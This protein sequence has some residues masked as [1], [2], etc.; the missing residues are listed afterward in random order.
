MNIDNNYLGINSAMDSNSI[1]SNGSSSSSINMNIDSS[2]M[3]VNAGGLP[4]R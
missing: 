1:N 2:G 3:M 4:S